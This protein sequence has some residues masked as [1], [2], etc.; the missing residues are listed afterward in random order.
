MKLLKKVGIGHNFLID[1]KELE[2]GDLIGQ[3]V[4]SF[5][6]MV[7]L[8]LSLPGCLARPRCSHK[9]IWQSNALEEEK[10]CRFH[11]RSRSYF[12]PASPQYK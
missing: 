2:T 3:G 10:N 11:Q 12:Q 8:R 4:S 5:F 6:V 9:A 1:R 7:G